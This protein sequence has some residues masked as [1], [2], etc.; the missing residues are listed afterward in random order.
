MSKCDYDADDVEEH[1]GTRIIRLLMEIRDL[2]RW[3]F[4]DDPMPSDPVEDAPENL[5]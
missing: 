2:L 3:R 1:D 5:T 4:R